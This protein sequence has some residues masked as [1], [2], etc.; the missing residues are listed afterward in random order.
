[1]RHRELID[2]LTRRD[3]VARA[4]TGGLAAVLLGA[5]PFARQLASPSTAFAADPLTDATL[6]AFADTMIPGRKATT[7]DLGNTIDPRAIAGVDNRPGAVEADAL[8]LYHN[9]RI[10]F[11]ALA[12]PFL[13]ELETRSAQFGADFTS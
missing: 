4:A 5:A 13:T 12:P 2:D 8:A 9:P 11:D 7:T 10:G 1:M 3:F 6:Q